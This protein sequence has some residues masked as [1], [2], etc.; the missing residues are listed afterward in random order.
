MCFDNA[1]LIR[2]LRLKQKPQTSPLEDF[3]K[4]YR[5]TFEVE[6]LINLPLSFLVSYTSSIYRSQK[7]KD[8]ISFGCR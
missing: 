3:I 5:I 7:I 4:I 8:D 1:F 6:N 2:H